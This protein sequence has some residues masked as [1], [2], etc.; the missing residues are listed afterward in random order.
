M[1]STYSQLYEN[2]NELDRDEWN[3][4]RFLANFWKNGTFNETSRKRM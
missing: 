3:A 1:G 2:Q 4:V